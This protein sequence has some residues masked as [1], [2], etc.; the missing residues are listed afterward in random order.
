MT[1]SHASC[2]HALE[3]KGVRDQTD[4]MLVSDHGFST[5]LSVVDLADSGSEEAP[6]L[7]PAREF[8]TPPSN[9]DIVVSGD[10]GSVMLYVI[11]HDKKVISQVVKYLQEWSYTGVLFTRQ[12]MEGTFTLAQAHIDAP[13]PPDVIIS[14]RWNA[15]KNDVGT[16]GMLTSDLCPYGPG[17]GM[18]GSLSA[19][20]MHNTFVAAGPDFH[21]GIVDH[22]PT[23][24]VDIAPTAL[25][26]LGVKQ[27]KTMDGRVV[28]E[29][30]TLPE[31]KIKSFE[32]NHLE[33]SRELEKVTWHQYLNLTEV[34]GVVYYDEGNG[35]QTQKQK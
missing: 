28:S 9:G 29:A 21:A 35:F 15:D 7:T 1:T 17:Q 16:P 26:I 11:G 24:N 8:K 19:F 2:L 31:A 3:E 14:M 30:L 5:I 25:W 6:V 10:G 32:P 34:N 33:A 20:D 4:I 18:H 22:L 23:G 12:A 13:N 27:P